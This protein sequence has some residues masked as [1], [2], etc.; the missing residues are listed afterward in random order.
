MNKL[1]KSTPLFGMLIF[2]TVILYWM[3]LGNVSA[4]VI[5]RWNVYISSKTVFI[6]LSLSLIIFPVVLYYFIP[7]AKLN[8]YELFLN[9][10]L[11]VLLHYIFKVVDD[12]LTLIIITMFLIIAISVGLYVLQKSGG[13]QHIK[14][15][16]YVRHIAAICVM[17]LIVPAYIHYNYMDTKERYVASFEERQNEQV[18]RQEELQHLKQDLQNAK[19]SILSTAAKTELLNRVII[20][21]SKEFGMK[22]PRLAVETLK[23]KNYNGQYNHGTKTVSINSQHLNDSLSSCLDTV[24]HECYHAYQHSV[25]D[26]L[27]QIDKEVYDDNLYFEKAGEWMLARTTY[28]DDTKTTQGYRDNQLEV[29]AREFA[30]EKRMKVYGFVGR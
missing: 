25:I 4:V 28:N 17:F 27:K 15:V 2:G 13:I 19:W 30:S 29:D 18:A 14:M 3:M 22:A 6:G 9:S 11:P 12:N 21:E 7:K 1:T 8:Y 23:K 20:Y 5:E 10:A 16:Y 26:I 24:L